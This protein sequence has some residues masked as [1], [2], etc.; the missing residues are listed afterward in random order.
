MDDD[1]RIVLDRPARPRRVP[2]VVDAARLAALAEDYV[3]RFGGPSANVMRMLER[4]IQRSVRDHGSDPRP[5]RTVASQVVARLVEARAI[6]DGRYAE[7]KALQLAAR[8]TSR[9]M[10][11]MR[12]QQRGL[13]EDEVA[14]GLA[15]SDSL[16]GDLASARRLVQRRRLGWLR[17]QPATVTV[18][19]QRLQRDKDLAVLLRA[20]F[21]FDVAKRALLPPPA[22]GDE[23]D[24]Q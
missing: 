7:V 11:A 10:V 14:R 4:H 12:L 18:A 16:G 17:P 5:L 20:G 9:R 2:P 24:G 23:D 19:A 6:D 13:G 22:D 8:G 15:E 1:R 3:Q 21:G